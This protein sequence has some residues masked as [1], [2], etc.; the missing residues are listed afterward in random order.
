[1]GRQFWYYHRVD[2]VGRLPRA[3]VVR[4]P[5]TPSRGNREDGDRVLGVGD[6]SG[7]LVDHQPRIANQ[8]LNAVAIGVLATGW[9][10]P[11]ETVDGSVGDHQYFARWARDLSAAPESKQEGS[12]RGAR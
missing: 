8:P 5:D 4:G 12:E 1:M 11:G 7:V 6:G 10:G 9:L 3:V 2:L